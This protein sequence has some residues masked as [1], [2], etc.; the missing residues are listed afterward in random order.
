MTVTIDS[1]IE[2]PMRD[3]AVLRADIFRTADAGPQ[4]VILFRTPYDKNL[5]NMDV[6]T[7]RQ[8][9]MGG[10]A[11]VV[12]DTR[13]RFASDGDWEGIAWHHEGPDTYDTVEWIAG[14]D[15]CDGNVGMAGASYLG[16]VQW[17]GAMEQPP[18]LKAIAPTMSTS[19]EFERFE[20]GGAFR[21]DHILSWLAFMAADWLQRR[22]AAGDNPDSETIDKIA[23]MATNPRMVMGELPIRDNPWFALDGFPITLSQLLD[24]STGHAPIFDYSRIEI[25]TLSVGGFFDVFPRATIMQFN[26]VV[27]QGA[28]RVADEHRLVMGPWLHAGILPH[29]QGEMNFGLLAAASYSRLPQKHLQFFDRHLKG[30]GEP[31]S[32][33][34]YFLAGR[35][36]WRTAETWPPEGISNKTLFLRG[37]GNAGIAGGALTPDPP[38]RDEPADNY[39]SD[40]MNPVPTHGGRVLYLGG[41]APGPLSQAHLESREDVLVYTGEPLLEELVV[42]G[43]VSISLFA[44]T[45]APDCDWVVKLLDAHPDGRAT[46]VAD[47]IMRAR[48]R[49]DYDVE[50]LITSR[51]PLEYR[52][53]L[54]PVAWSF[55]VGHRI[56]VHV[57]SSNFPHIDRNMQTGNPPGVDGEGAV[58]SQAVFHTSAA[59]SK[60]ILPVMNISP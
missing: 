56:R 49:D 34:E 52:I 16:I 44:A 20:T 11:C 15:W 59:D 2:I 35:N 13:G 54:G 40:P 50:Q 60:L 45:S 57:Q 53:D 3:G 9:V 46:F 26:A 36:Q 23:R 24:G 10:Y 4:P 19:A 21:L 17:L 8:A 33:I 32:R 27:E 18:H 7:P 37:D 30:K 43:N 14:Q 55:Q 25:P 12:Q 48:F 47:G 39:R 38:A 51:E 28:N 6:L 5:L 31:L 42:T 58:A 22:I 41:L 29:Y 1:N